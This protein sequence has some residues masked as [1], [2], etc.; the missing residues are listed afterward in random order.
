LL[1]L[2][3][4]IVIG[5][6][7]AVAAVVLV[8]EDH[9]TQDV[10]F[11]RVHTV[12]AQMAAQRDV[13]V[14]LGKSDA[15]EVIAPI[16][17][18]A[19]AVSGVDYV[20]VVDASGVR[21][22]HPD[23]GMIGR[24]VSSNHEQVL[25]GQPFRG[26]EVGPRGVTL[27][28]KEP[29]RFNG[30]IVGTISVGILQSEIRRDLLAIVAGFA[31][32]LL[33]A[34]VLGTICSAWAGRV[35]RRR[36]YGVEPEEVA[37]LLQSQ[38]ALLFS[39]HDGVLGVDEGGRLTLLNDEASRLLGVGEEALGR[40]AREVLDPDVEALLNSEG[41]AAEQTQS[42]LSG[43]RILLATRREATS[44]N[45][46]LGKTLTLQDRTELEATLRELQGQ[47]SLADALRSQTHEFSNRL[48]VLAGYLSVGEAGEAQAYIER[49]TGPASTID[50]SRPSDPALTGLLGAN[51]SVAREAGVRLDIDPES[52]VGDGW[53]ADEDVLT[54]VG[55]LLKNAIEAAGDGGTAS[56]K[57]RADRSGLTLSVDD[58]GPGIAPESVERVFRRGVTSKG[59]EEGTG[60]TRGIGLALV[61]RIV[62]RRGGDI[63]VDSGKLGGARISVEWTEPTGGQTAFSSTG[64]VP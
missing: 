21:V 11:E 24:H 48:H 53:R 30:E 19:T 13:Q 58:S 46:S 55:N 14:H 28:A 4:G 47:R 51:A 56:V 52:L 49:L 7:S 33:G 64:G 23:S 17:G 60:A 39:V 22:A 57:L 6:L 1:L 5:L 16:A 26:T 8:F 43:E 27:R 61:D 62:T 3:V 35:V 18:L 42:V 20:T 9:R 25:D 45:R 29:V 15:V 12:A 10:A 2:Q 32:W 36:I 38:Q 34:A 59:T 44:G 37:G 41:H 50:T 40:P 54:V 63:R 31:P